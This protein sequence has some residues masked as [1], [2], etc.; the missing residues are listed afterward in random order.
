MSDV[1]AEVDDDEPADA[2]QA[3]AIIRAQQAGA[4]ARLG[5]RTGLFF[6]V[7]GAVWALTGSG[8]YLAGIGVLPGAVAGWG[9]L[10]LIVAGVVVS[11]VVSMR[12][13]RGVSGPSTR[14]SLLYGLTWPVVMAA[15]VVLAAGLAGPVGLPAPTLAVVVPALFALLSGALY[16]LSGAVWTSVPQFVLGLWI[17]AIGVAS[18]FVGSPANA[19]LLGLGVG[20]ALALMGVREARRG[21]GRAR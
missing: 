7:W 12:A 14:Q 15:L 18:A 19:L 13:G 9:S 3:L 10:L 8:F 17:V 16:A 4:V 1:H 6:L 20:G 21:R 11:A 5:P 2:A